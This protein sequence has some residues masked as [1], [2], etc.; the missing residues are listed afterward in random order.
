MHVDFRRLPS[1]D[2]LQYADTIVQ[3]YEVSR[4]MR[5]KRA[6]VGALASIRNEWCALTSIQNGGLACGTLCVSQ[7]G[8]QLTTEDLLRS[9]G[10]WR[11]VCVC[12]VTDDRLRGRA[13]QHRKTSRCITLA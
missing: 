13:A 3:G 4:E 8:R 5:R 9:P 2:R 10:S 1:S 11:C 7:L 12:V 6:A